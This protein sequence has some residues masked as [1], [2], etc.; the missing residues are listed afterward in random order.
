MGLLG[1]VDLLKKS[2]LRQEKVILDE[3][4]DEYVFVRQMTAHEK[5]VWEISQVEKS[6]VGKKTS[7]DFT[8]DDYRAKLAVVTIC[9]EKG[10]LLFQP[11]DYNELSA[12]I[13]AFKLEKIVDVAQKLNTITEEDREEI[14]K[15]S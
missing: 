9:D 2:V 8:L 12:N 14:V 1:R 6:G 10:V 11:E 7:Y 3:V 5:S 4:T 15:N 13:S